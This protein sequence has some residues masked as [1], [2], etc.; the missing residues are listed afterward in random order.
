MPLLFGVLLTNGCATT[1]VP[2]AA[3]VKIIRDSTAVGECV[4]V[5]TLETHP[6]LPGYSVA[7]ARN[8]TAQL[9]GNTLLVTYQSLGS[10][11]AGEAYRCP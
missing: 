10:L 7:D 11:I 8:L 6:D 1:P 5:G 2:G 9:G 3:D 4:A